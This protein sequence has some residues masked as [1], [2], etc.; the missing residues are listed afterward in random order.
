[1]AKTRRGSGER[2]LERGDA[3]PIPGTRT[4]EKLAFEVL[5]L[6]GDLLDHLNDR[7]RQHIDHPVDHGPVVAWGL[8]LEQFSDQVQ[9]PAGSQWTVMR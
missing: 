1:M 9:L 3:V 4:P 8:A 2:W 5:D 7:V 6:V